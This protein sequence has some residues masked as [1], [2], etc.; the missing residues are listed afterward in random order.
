MSTILKTDSVRVDSRNSNIGGNLD[1]NYLSLYEFVNQIEEEDIIKELEKKP[2]VVEPEQKIVIDLRSEKM[3]AFE[4]A[5]YNNG[6]SSEKMDFFYYL[7]EDGQSEIDY[8]PEFRAFEIDA[9]EE[10]EIEENEDDED[11]IEDDGEVYSHENQMSLS[12]EEQKL[13]ERK[14]RG[15]SGLF[16]VGD[17]LN[18]SY[19]GK[20]TT[21]G[22]E[23]ICICIHKKKI[24]N[25]NASVILRNI[26]S[27][28][29]VELT[30]SYYYN[31]AYNFTFSDYKRKEYY[32][33][34]AKLYYLRD[35]LNQESKV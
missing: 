34:R 5:F 18:V 22:F 16:T 30:I 14:L 17:I 26:L 25:P 32:Y 20:F 10:V 4:Q 15:S 24:L 9:D 31:R 29:G 6:M 11:D 3:K 23:G 27:R 35:R 33:K 2:L 19:A 1:D 8:H 13:L 7:D 12:I 21:F 28:I